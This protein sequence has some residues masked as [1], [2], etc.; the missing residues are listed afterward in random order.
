MKKARA[1]YLAHSREKQQVSGSEHQDWRDDIEQTH[2]GSSCPSGEVWAKLACDLSPLSLACFALFTSLTAVA[3]LSRDP[4]ERA[5]RQPSGSPG[6]TARSRPQAE[7][8]PPGNAA[9]R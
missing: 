6:E 8:F 7:L 3:K 5:V 1:H 4:E 9:P 2:C